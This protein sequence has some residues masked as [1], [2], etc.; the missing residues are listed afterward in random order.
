MGVGE[1]YELI[2]GGSELTTNALWYILLAVLTL[3]S[4]SRAAV[5]N[6]IHGLPVESGPFDFIVGGGMLILMLELSDL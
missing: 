6:G 5:L 4:V 3:L 2:V 1:T